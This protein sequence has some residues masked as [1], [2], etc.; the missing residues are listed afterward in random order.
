MQGEF[1][2]RQ[3]HGGFCSRIVTRGAHTVVRRLLSPAPEAPL[4]EPPQRGSRALI[5]STH[6]R[7]Q[8]L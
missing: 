6:Q 1:H 3:Q 8:P 4:E 7:S 5:P 2:G